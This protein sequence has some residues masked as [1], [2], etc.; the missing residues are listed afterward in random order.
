MGM[1][2]E[3]RSDTSHVSPVLQEAE[4]ED[5]ACNKTQRVRLPLILV[6]L[7]SC[8]TWGH[9]G[10]AVTT[11]TMYLIAAEM[12]QHGQSLNLQGQRCTRRGIVKEESHY[13]SH[14]FS[15]PTQHLSTAA[16]SA[17]SL[18]LMLILEANLM[19]LSGFLQLVTLLSLL[20]SGQHSVQTLP[21]S[22][23]YCL[24]ERE[25]TGIIHP[26][27]KNWRQKCSGSKRSPKELA[28]N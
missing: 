9:W 18:E 2:D 14:S 16:K 23:D 6:S 3:D 22:S 15:S 24:P 1:R 27:S 4:C 25:V 26:I 19:S 11:Q 20:H 13:L 8:T 12:W 17:Q 28:I 5:G 21:N 10:T 7:V